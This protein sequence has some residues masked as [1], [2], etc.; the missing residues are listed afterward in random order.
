MKAAVFSLLLTLFSGSALADE[1]RCISAYGAK[2]CGYACEAA[3]GQVKCAQTPYGA[4]LAANGTLTCWDPPVRH[5]H[6]MRNTPA[7]QCLSEYGTTACGYG[8]VAQYG[9]IKCAQT[10][11]HHCYADSGQLFCSDGT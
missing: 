11:G 8:C 3:Y 4:C 9:A 1:A 7:A 5:A 10:P 6:R 2:A